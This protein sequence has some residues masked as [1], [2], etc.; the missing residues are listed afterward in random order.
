M[1]DHLDDTGRVEVGAAADLVVLD[2][3]IL[4]GAPDAVASAV[5]EATYVDGVAV[6]RR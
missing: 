1:A 4:A 3:D 6:Y 5:V 2:R